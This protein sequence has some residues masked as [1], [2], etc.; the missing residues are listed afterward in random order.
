[1]FFCTA[2]KT[3]LILG[4][5]SNIRPEISVDRQRAY[6]SRRMK[7]RLTGERPL[8]VVRRWPCCGAR[9]SS[10]HLMHCIFGVVRWPHSRRQPRC[11]ALCCCILSFCKSPFEV[12]QA[13]RAASRDREGGKSKVLFV[14]GMPIWV[15]IVYKY[16]CV[17]AHSP[18]TSRPGKQIWG[19]VG[20]VGCS[21]E[22][23]N[24]CRAATLCRTDG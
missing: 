4:V 15:R 20:E 5:S 10:T 16:R 21:L 19:K 23:L 11:A 18:V 12:D 1:M 17:A 13:Q 22:K 24:H 9:R 14:A 8:F 7:W 2:S 6:W 3:T